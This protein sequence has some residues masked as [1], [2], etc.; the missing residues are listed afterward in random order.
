MSCWAELSEMAM[1]VQAC[2]YSLDAHACMCSTIFMRCTCTVVCTVPNCV[3]I[4][5]HILLYGHTLYGVHVRV[6]CIYMY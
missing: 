5:M 4:H 3:Q 1:T 6:H 2:Q